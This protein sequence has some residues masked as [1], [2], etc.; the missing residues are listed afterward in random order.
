MEQGRI[1]EGME[2]IHRKEGSRIEERE[3]AGWVLTRRLRKEINGDWFI[4]RIILWEYGLNI[5]H[6]ANPLILFLKTR[7]IVFIYFILPVPVPFL[8]WT[9]CDHPSTYKWKYICGTWQ[10]GRHMQHRSFFACGR[11]FF[12]TFCRECG[13]SDVSYRTMVFHD[14]MLVTRF[15]INFSEYIIIIIL[16]KNN[17]ILLNMSVH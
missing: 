1:V 16:P 13:F 11:S 4:N 17:H 9:F 12:H 5:D 14:P 8:C 7:E 3:C 2:W 15:T 10:Q 6:F